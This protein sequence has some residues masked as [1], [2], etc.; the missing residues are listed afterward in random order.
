MERGDVLPARTERGRREDTDRLREP[1][2]VEVRGL[3]D[4]VED[5]DEVEACT[6]VA[7]AR[8]GEAR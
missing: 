4:R 5:E 8:A 2:A 7:G 3:A 1:L 6:M